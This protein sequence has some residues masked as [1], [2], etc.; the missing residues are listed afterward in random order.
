MD[1]Y[2]YKNKIFE[3]VSK[4]KEKEIYD[5][6]Y[7]CILKSLSLLSSN[8]DLNKKEL[9]DLIKYSK[10]KIANLDPSSEN[11]QR[12]TKNFIKLKKPIF[13]ICIYHLLTFIVFTSFSV[14][15]LFQM[16]V[17]D[18]KFDSL[19]K[20]H[21]YFF[22]KLRIY[23]DLESY[24]K[25]ILTKKFSPDLFTYE[26][27]TSINLQYLQNLKSMENEII[28]Y[29]EKIDQKIIQKNFPGFAFRNICQDFNW[30]AHSNTVIGDYENMCPD[31]LNGKLKDGIIPTNFLL[32]DE[33]E[34]RIKSY[35]LLDKN[36]IIGILSHSKTFE[37][38]VSIILQSYYLEDMKI[39]ILNE[40]NQEFSNYIIFNFVLVLGYTIVILILIL[41]DYIWVY[42]LEKGKLVVIRKILLFLPMFVT[43]KNPYT[44]RLIFKIKKKLI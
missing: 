30:E 44:Q 38:R 9:E 43:M 29:L 28:D 26:L 17:F 8:I 18:Q 27:P 24:S 42:N 7:E 31:I 39:S 40:K 2:S 11:K 36:Q 19:A 14:I 33:N 1:I 21:Y 15:F 10:E 34:N 13:R 23:S 37:M 25:I 12:I 22:R 6:F 3:L 20:I 16:N 4:L 35:D 32:L 41:F 5:I